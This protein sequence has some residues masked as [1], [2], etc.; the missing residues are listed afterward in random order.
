MPPARGR[1]SLSYD[2]F[3]EGAEVKSDDQSE[4]M[5]H[6]NTGTGIPDSVPLTAH[7]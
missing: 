5:F 7:P 1:W 6:V 4:H 3:V 2:I